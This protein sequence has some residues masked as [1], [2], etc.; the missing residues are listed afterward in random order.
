MFAA[1][2]ASPM[3]LSPRQSKTALCARGLGF[4]LAFAFAGTS[5]LAQTGGPVRR[6]QPV[7]EPPVARALPVDQAS[8][9]STP[10]PVPAA[11][12]TPAP[13]DASQPA[14]EGPPPDR[15]QLEYANALFGR[16][17]YDLAVPEFEKYLDQYPNAPGRAQAYF[18]L[19]ESYR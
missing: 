17:L 11:G 14:A 13:P 1:K 18:F 12:T 9:S 10:R 19:G 8:S 15:R 16:K 6:A 7:N 5:G 3:S 4:F 2:R